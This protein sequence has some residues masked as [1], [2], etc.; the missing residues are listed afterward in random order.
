MF[1]FTKNKITPDVQVEDKLKS[2]SDLFSKYQLCQRHSY[3]PEAELLITAI[4]SSIGK[5]FK[6]KKTTARQQMLILDM[7]LSVVNAAISWDEKKG[8]P[9]KSNKLEILMLNLGAKL[10]ELKEITPR[11]F[12]GENAIVL[13]A[14]NLIHTLGKMKEQL[15]DP[16]IKVSPK[17]HGSSKQGWG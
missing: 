7:A 10:A 9:V 2:L 16:E 1:K 13:S 14:Q 3:M 6:A 11:Q 17:S 15:R 5:H 12:F 4:T 8:K